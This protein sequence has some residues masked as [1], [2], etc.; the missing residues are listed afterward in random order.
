MVQLIK[1]F[2]TFYIQSTERIGFMHENLIYFIE[3]L[4]ELR[5]FIDKKVISTTLIRTIQPILALFWT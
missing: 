4:D 5:L 2:F 3:V 1:V